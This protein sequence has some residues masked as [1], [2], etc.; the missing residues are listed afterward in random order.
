MLKKRKRDTGERS[1]CIVPKCGRPRFAQGLC[2]TH[3]RQL[4]MTGEF[5]PIRPYR[6]R[7]P[8]TVKFAGLRLSKHCAD[9]LGRYAARRD[10]S[11]GAAIA[12]V[13]EGALVQ[14]K[15]CRSRKDRTQ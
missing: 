11:L 4:L 14:K 6:Q 5:K 3:H 10:I 8:G 9:V 12:D 13:L 2:Q 7:K 1:I 15:P